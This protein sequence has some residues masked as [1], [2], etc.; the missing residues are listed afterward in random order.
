VDRTA[1]VMGRWTAQREGDIRRLA[2]ARYH[3]VGFT[4]RQGRPESK[5]GKGRKGKIVELYIKAASPVRKYLASCT[6]PGLL[7]VTDE[8]G[9][10]RT[11]DPANGCALQE[12]G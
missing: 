10:P 11:P 12:E 2:R 3:G 1:Y 7:F 6:F 5:R 9:K 8:A 4:I